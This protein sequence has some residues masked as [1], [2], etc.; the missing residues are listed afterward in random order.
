[1]NKKTKDLIIASSLSALIILG[2]V[3]L[4]ISPLD[5]LFSNYDKEVKEVSFCDSKLAEDAG[6]IK[7]KHKYLGYETCIRPPNN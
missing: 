2:F 3:Y 5:I 1:M 6:F 7:V 4:S